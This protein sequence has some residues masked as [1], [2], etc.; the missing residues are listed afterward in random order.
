MFE[1]HSQEKERQSAVFFILLFRCIKK[2]FYLCVG[3]NH[4]EYEGQV[5]IIFIL[6]HDKFINSESCRNRKLCVNVQQKY[7]KY[8]FLAGI[9]GT[10]IKVVK[11]VNVPFRFQYMPGLKKI[12]FVD[13]GGGGAW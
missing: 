1:K 4:S 3:D 8:V 5:K 2:R 6:K 13:V 12:S 7:R 10:S 11:I 9:Q